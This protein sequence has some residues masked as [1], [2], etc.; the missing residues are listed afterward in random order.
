[1]T[2]LFIA[3]LILL[4]SSLGLCAT[5][6]QNTTGNC[7][8]AVANVNGNVLIYCE[9]IDPKALGRL[10]EL[11]DLKDKNLGEARKTLDEKIQ[12]A[13][14]WAQKYR[15]L[16]MRLSNSAVTEELSIQAGRSMQNGD[17]VTA[18]V[19]LDELL[20]RQEVDIEKIAANHFSR[21]QVYD[22]QYQ[23]QSALPHYEKA[24][25]YRPN[26]FRYAF[27]YART[28]QFH[29][30]FIKA[31][32][33]YNEQL[34]VL[35]RDAAHDQES[36]AHI[37]SMLNNLG[38]IYVAT[39]KLK[40]A[41]ECYGES[42]RI[43]RELASNSPSVYSMDLVQ[44]LNNL[45]D[46]YKITGRTKE[47]L[48]L[49]R[50]GILVLRQHMASIPDRFPPVLGPLIERTATLLKAGSAN[51]A[52]AEE[53]INEYV[54]IM[55]GLAETSPP[56]FLRYLAQSLNMLA[57]FKESYLKWDEAISSY[58]ESA[59]IL[60]GLVAINP[61]AY[62][63]ELASTLGHLGLVYGLTWNRLQS[64]KAYQEA[65]NIYRALYEVYPALHKP[66]LAD[67][68]RLLARAE[69]T[70]EPTEGEKHY[71]EAI[72]LYR[73]LVIS[74]GIA[75]R[76]IL[77][78]TLLDFV[79][80][81]NLTKSGSTPTE[82]EYCEEAVGIYRNLWLENAERYTDNLSLALSIFTFV[83]SRSAHGT[84]TACR[85]AREMETFPRANKDADQSKDAL[86]EMACR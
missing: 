64:K 35:R 17:F 1:M 76:P 74:D 77:A 11:L 75:Y 40:D 46:L 59:T 73:E 3:F 62:R 80:I 60:S 61:A 69:V 50:D 26:V 55:R 52:D 83:L 28:L 86:I 32:V 63:L 85:L 8:P 70:T 58:E 49:S 20:L 57:S 25:R 9:G 16:E 78:D 47:S 45:S 82:I 41:E 81:I 51:Y 37:A 68:L 5:T 29:Y 24:Y 66:Y 13:N 84:P 53:L 42:L 43:R 56:A 22:L 10:N 48:A 36:Q 4:S 12:E 15:D 34:T 14:E 39:Q 54:S 18:G 2:F 38:L 67:T 72:Q 6:T 27:E 21:A 33:V 65:V 79:S 7:S 71:Q 30:E 31:V 44:T 19:K 23:E